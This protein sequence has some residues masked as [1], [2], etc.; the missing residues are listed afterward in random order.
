MFAAVE[1]V[2]W[3]TV[4]EKLGNWYKHVKSENLC[5]RF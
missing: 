3:K 2:N 5:K 1:N 4:S